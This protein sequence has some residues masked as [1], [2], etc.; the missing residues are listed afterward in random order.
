MRTAFYTLLARLRD[1]VRP[2]AGDADFE[3]ELDMHLAMAAEDTVRRGMSPDEARRQARLELGG[4]TQL[5]EAARAARG[6]PGL[7]TVWL[8]GKLGVRMLRKSW[9]LTLVGG[10]AM[11]LTIGLGASI[12][13]IWDT[14]A[15][16][17]L[18]L[19]EGDRVVA[20]Q[21]FDRVSQRVDM[22]TPLADFRRW[23]ETLRS[24]EFVSAM[25]PIEP[26]LLTGHGA[27]SPV[28]AAEM[29]ASAFQLARV[30]PLLGR[31]LIDHDEREGAEPVAV[32]SYDL[33]QS[34]FSS[35]PAVLGQ[36]IQ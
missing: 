33:W 26:A 31:A 12:F 2:A 35:D 16:T 9:G 11:A 17:R 1:F 10:L 4:V 22:T 30:Q 8:D 36:R 23:R 25:R 15:G 32:I 14:F 24:V 29:T 19:D 34:A 13:N 6:L 28:R 20:I 3:Q 7:D 21:P 18:P 5:R 27:V